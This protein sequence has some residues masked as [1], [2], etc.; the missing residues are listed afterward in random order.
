MDLINFTR[1]SF[2]PDFKVVGFWERSS[3]ETPVATSIFSGSASSST[4][5][6]P[7]SPRRCTW[8]ISG[9]A[10]YNPLSLSPHGAP[11]P[12]EYLFLPVLTAFSFSSCP[13]VYLPVRLSLVLLPL[14]HR[15]G[16]PSLVSPRA[17]SWNSAGM[18]CTGL[19]LTNMT[20]HA[21]VAY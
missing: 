14:L 5:P 13:P 21:H 15:K 18:R 12:L 3:G 16:P 17:A 8:A 19:E 1:A 4:S 9:R 7:T 2:S 20:K 11:F 6:R 10:F